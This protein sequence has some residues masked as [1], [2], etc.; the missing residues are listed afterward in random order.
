MLIFYAITNQGSKSVF[1][2]PLLNSFPLAIYAQ[3][4]LNG[5][6]AL[7]SSNNKVYSLCVD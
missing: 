2:A 5:S 4:L 7:G 6:Q 3:Q 1:F